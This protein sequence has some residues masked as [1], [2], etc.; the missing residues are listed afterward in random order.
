MLALKALSQ[1]PESMTGMSIPNY[2]IPL[3]GTILLPN[4][5]PPKQLLNFTKLN[6]RSM[7]M[8]SKIVASI[9]ARM[10]SSRLPGKVLMPATSEASM[11]EYMIHSVKQSRLIDDIIVATTVNETDQPIVELC[12]KLGVKYYRGSEDDVLLRVLEAHK[13]IDSKI[14][15]ELTGDCPL[16][17]AQIVDKI[18]QIYLD[19]DYDYVSNSHVRSYPDGFDVQVFSVDC[20]EDVSNSKN[21]QYDRENVSSYIY[22]SDKYKLDAVIADK[23]LF[24][25]DLRVTLDDTGDYKLIKSIIENL[26]PKHH[27]KFKALDVVQLLKSRPELLQLNKDARIS[28]APYQT[29]ADKPDNG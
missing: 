11:L 18:I 24:W 8:K 13:S 10:T 17:D 2:A 20:L 9:E 1:Q 26:E 3:M 7:Q 5:Y 21:E 28:N 15:V 6:L 14:I 25:P 4:K 27:N 16:I 12:N 19:N 22:R 29:I 23:E